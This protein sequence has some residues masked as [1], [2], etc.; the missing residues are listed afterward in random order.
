[1]VFRAGVVLGEG[2]EEGEGLFG[3]VTIGHFGG[4]LL[5]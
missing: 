3:E 2:G 5:G 4:S 1:M